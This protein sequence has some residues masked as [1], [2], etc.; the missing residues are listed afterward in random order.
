[1]QG[2]RRGREARKREGE[3]GLVAVLAK[4]EGAL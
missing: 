3:N 4:A 1:M 2:A